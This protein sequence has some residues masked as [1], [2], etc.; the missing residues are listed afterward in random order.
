MLI[1]APQA[2][3]THVYLTELVIEGIA[4]EKNKP[5]S[6]HLERLQ[7]LIQ[8]VLRSPRGKWYC[9]VTYQDERAKGDD[10][11]NRVFSACSR[12]CAG[13]YLHFVSSGQPLPSDLMSSHKST[14]AFKPTD[15]AT[16]RSCWYL[17]ATEN[18]TDNSEKS[19]FQ[20]DGMNS[21]FCLHQII[22]NLDL[23]KGFRDQ[24]FQLFIA[25]KM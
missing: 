10:G 17:F 24:Q 25:L 12:S 15:I 11:R 20:G 21:R 5:R 23:W 8:W 13:V 22:K 4:A 19:G 14:M 9:E 1:W 16:I 18:G 3:R 6:R 7:H 2:A